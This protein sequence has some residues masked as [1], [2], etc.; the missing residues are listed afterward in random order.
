MTRKGVRFLFS[1]RV[2]CVC[3]GFTVTS[4]EKKMRDCSSLVGP[5]PVAAWFELL[6]SFGS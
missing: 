1:S 6:V 5:L 4:K 3:Y 2:Q